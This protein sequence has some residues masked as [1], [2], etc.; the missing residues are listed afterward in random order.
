V[1]TTQLV[2]AHNALSKEKDARSDADRSLVEEKV[3][4]QVA[5]QALHSSNNAK[6][7]LAQ[8]LETT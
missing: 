3:A 8:E 6:A 1:L 7:K 4:W 2:A 5:E